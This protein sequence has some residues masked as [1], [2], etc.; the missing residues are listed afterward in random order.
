[1]P[2]GWQRSSNG[3]GWII[4]TEETSAWEDWLLS[5]LGDMYFDI[6]EWSGGNYAFTDD[7]QYNICPSCAE[8]SECFSINGCS[9]GSLDFLI[10]P[11]FYIPNE[12]SLKL[13]FDYWFQYQIGNQ[14]NNILQVLVQKKFKTTPVYKEINSYGENTGYHMGVYICLGQSIH[15]LEHSNAIPFNQFS[16]FQEISEYVEEHSKV[17]VFLGEGL[18]KIKK[19]AEQIACEESI[20]KINNSSTK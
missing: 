2:V 13:S 7:E 8:Y 3:R 11:T 10:T 18:H 15:G 4:G 17:L 19:K 1:M 14:H 6:P 12:S 16:N 5:Q 20:N 9:D